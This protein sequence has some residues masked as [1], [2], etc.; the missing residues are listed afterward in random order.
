MHET[1][2][3]TTGTTPKRTINLALQGGGAHGAFTW[4]ALDCLLADRR[5]TI[6]GIS[7]TSAGAMNAVVVTQGLQ[8]GGPEGARA[9]LR[10][11]WRAISDAGQASPLKR[12][13]INILFG[14]WSLD[15]SPGYIMVDMLQ[16]FASPYD[17]NPLRLNPL[18]DLLEKMIDFEKVRACSDMELYISATN[19]ETGRVHVFNRAEM[20]VDMIMAS[21]CLPQMFHAV[22][23]DGKPYWDG[24]YMGNPVLFPFYDTHASKDIVI[25]QINPVYRD[26]VPKTARDIQNRVNEITFNSSLMKELRT[27]DFVTCMIEEGKLQNSG[28]SPVYVHMIHSRKRMRPLGASSKLNTEWAFLTYLFEI[29]YTTAERWLDESYDCLGRCSSIDIGKMF[30]NLGS[31]SPA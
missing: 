23:I 21:A 1:S 13:L 26:G 17:I 25:V 12:N 14:N 28:L 27:I 19:V 24:G 29:G 30:G 15:N 8:E 20:T 5:L 6:A 2:S 3:Q 7:G 22:E 18:R 9:A 10:Q 16:R 31:I 4:G 11:F